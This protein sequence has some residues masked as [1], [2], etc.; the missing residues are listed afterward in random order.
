VK[1]EGGEVFAK[2]P[3]PAVLDEYLATQKLIIKADTAHQCS[4]ACDDK[5]EKITAAE[6]A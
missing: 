6:A 3:P 2:L 5:E 1:V 4:G